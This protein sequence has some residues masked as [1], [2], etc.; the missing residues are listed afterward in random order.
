MGSQTKRLRRAKARELR[1][2]VSYVINGAIKKHTRNSECWNTE[3]ETFAM[4]LADGWRIEL[5]LRLHHREIEG[6][7]GMGA[8]LQSEPRDPVE[9]WHLVM[10]LW[11]KGRP[12]RSRDWEDLA[13]F[14]SRVATQTGYEGAY[15]NA[16]AP[17]DRAPHEPHH[18]VW[19]SDDAVT[20]EDRRAMAR[21]VALQEGA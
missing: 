4:M 9:H 6:G 15:I 13:D 10:Q 12:E 14:V 1:T 7:S 3:G 16:L 20:D 8:S 5:A 2:A 17:L 11:P 19:H 21:R 18:F